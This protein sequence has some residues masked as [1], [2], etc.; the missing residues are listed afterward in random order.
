MVKP[1]TPSRGR[2]L[3][4]TKV[5]QFLRNAIGAKQSKHVRAKNEGKIIQTEFDYSK[6]QKLSS[7]VVMKGPIVQRSY[8]FIKRRKKQISPSKEGKNKYKV[9]RSKGGDWG[10]RFS[11]PEKRARPSRRRCDE[12]NRS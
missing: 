7:I 10:R 5:E 2:G 11:H 3:T 1:L 8:K 9:Q 4:D 6:V 12:W